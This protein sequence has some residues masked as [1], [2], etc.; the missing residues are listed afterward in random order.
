MWIF[1]FVRFCRRNWVANWTN[2]DVLRHSRIQGVKCWLATVFV[3]RHGWLKRI[4]SELTQRKRTSTTSACSAWS[5]DVCVCSWMSSGE[6][7]SSSFSSSPSRSAASSSSSSSWKKKSPSSKGF[8]SI[9][10]L[11]LIRK[12]NWISRLFFF[13]S[14]SSQKKEMH[15]CLPLT[16]ICPK[17]CRKSMFD[18]YHKLTES[19]LLLIFIFRF[20]QLLNDPTE[21]LEKIFLD[22]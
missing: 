6:T 20:D 13:S 18:S 21:R 11:S 15:S 22:E 9:E 1:S 16:P 8:S 5:S 2:K 19:C 17:C 14:P 10:Y 7:R 3:R 4:S 12:S